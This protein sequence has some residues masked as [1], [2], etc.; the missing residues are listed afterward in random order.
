MI[1]MIIQDELKRFYKLMLRNKKVRLGSKIAIFRVKRVTLEPRSTH[2]ISFKKSEKI[3]GVFLHETS[4][5][6]K[7]KAY[8][9]NV[10][11]FDAP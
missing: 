4:H 1:L 5:R 11:A 8:L 3:Q 7:S 9:D 6:K 10:G 2:E